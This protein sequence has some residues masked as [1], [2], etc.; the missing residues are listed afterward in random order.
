LELKQD[1]FQKW[2]GIYICCNCFL[3]F[4]DCFRDITYE[5]FLLKRNVIAYSKY[6][7]NAFNMNNGVIFWARFRMY[8]VA[9]NIVLFI[10]VC[11]VLFW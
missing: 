11:N 9:V 6:T 5:C 1:F 4:S 7:E 3:L 2:W 8:M 10:I